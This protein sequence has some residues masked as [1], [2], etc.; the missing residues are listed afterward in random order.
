MTVCASRAFGDETLR[1]HIA[2]NGENINAK[3]PMG[4]KLS[5]GSDV[6]IDPCSGMGNMRCTAS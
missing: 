3:M 4:I 6:F 2:G 5:S 1:A